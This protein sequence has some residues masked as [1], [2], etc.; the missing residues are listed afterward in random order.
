MRK[1]YG[2]RNIRPETRLTNSA[3]VHNRAS[4]YV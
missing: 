4:G 3:Q 1:H 2:F